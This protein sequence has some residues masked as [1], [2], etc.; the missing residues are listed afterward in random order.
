M[1]GLTTITTAQC[2]VS[3]EVSATELLAMYGR[4]AVIELCQK[5]GTQRCTEVARWIADSG[6]ELFRHGRGSTRQ[7]LVIFTHVEYAHLPYAILALNKDG[8]IE[9]IERGIHM[10]EKAEFIETFKRSGNSAR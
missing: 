10:G 1:V 6:Y 9:V 5:S 2:A 3:K 8:L 7:H 4:V